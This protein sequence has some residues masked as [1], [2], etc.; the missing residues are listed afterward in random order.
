MKLHRR[1]C[2]LFCGRRDSLG[3]R[4]REQTSPGAGPVI[5]VE[6]AKGT[7]EFETYPDEAPKTVAHDRRRS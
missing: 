5:V 6:T 1:A 3:G 7:F 4:A 2:W